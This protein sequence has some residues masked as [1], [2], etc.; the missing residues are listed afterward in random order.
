MDRAINAYYSVP[1][2]VRHSATIGI[3]KKKMKIFL[4]DEAKNNKKYTYLLK[5]Y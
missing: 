3:L 1:N 5:N 4:N 2:D